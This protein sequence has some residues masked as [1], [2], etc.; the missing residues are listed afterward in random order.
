MLNEVDRTNLD[1]QLYSVLDYNLSNL[2]RGL[3]KN[4]REVI[5]MKECKHMS[6]VVICVANLRQQTVRGVG[7]IGVIEYL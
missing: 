3:V 6:M 4:K 1:E 2:S 7:S 5:M